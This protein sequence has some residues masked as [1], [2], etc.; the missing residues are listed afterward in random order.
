M[1]VRRPTGQPVRDLL[2]TDVHLEHDG[3]ACTVMGLR[4]EAPGMTIALLVD[5]SDWATNAL[6]SLRDGLHRFLDALPENHEVGLFTIS[7]QVRRRTGFTTDRDELK[8][9]ADRLFADPGGA[10]LL[11]GLFETWNRRFETEDAW[12]VFVLVVHDSLEPSHISERRY[13][14][15]LSEPR[16]RAATV[17]AVLLQIDRIGQRV[18]TDPL[19][20]P[21]LSSTAGLR[22]EVVDLTSRTSGT[23]RSLTVATALPQE[24]S[25]LAAELGTDHE[26]ARDRYHVIYE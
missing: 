4:P 20:R 24:L 22:R 19:N 6:P 16:A 13:N 21:R 1:S 9:E 25:D 14:A 10:V 5:N 8:G 3:T 23:F 2:A 12:P 11:K 18:Y 26:R 17:H 7:S 15:F